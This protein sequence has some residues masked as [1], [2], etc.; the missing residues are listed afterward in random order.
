MLDVQRVAREDETAFHVHD[1]VDFAHGGGDGGGGA[2]QGG[3]VLGVEFES[4]WA[5][6]RWSGRR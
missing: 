5:A 1:A 4:R 2:F 3:F 6:A